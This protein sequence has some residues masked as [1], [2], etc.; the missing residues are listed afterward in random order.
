[1][2]T[3]RSKPQKPVQHDFSHYVHD[4]VTR[5]RQKAVRAVFE[6][7]WN[8]Y[9]EH[10]WLRDELAPVSGKGKTTF[11]GWGGTLVDALDTL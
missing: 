11:G 9:K 2:P 3:G 10:A 7:S 8:S 5:N 6:R 4:P 1:L